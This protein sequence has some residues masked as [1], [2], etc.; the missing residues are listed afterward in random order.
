[1]N[2]FYTNGKEVYD[3][4]IARP[5]DFIHQF[6]K[7]MANNEFLLNHFGITLGELNGLA[8]YDEDTDLITRLSNVHNCHLIDY[9]ISDLFCQVEAPEDEDIEFNFET[10]KYLVEKII[11]HTVSIAMEYDDKVT[12]DRLSRLKE[13]FPKGMWSYETV[14]I[15]ECSCPNDVELNDIRILATLGEVHEIAN[16]A[17][18]FG[19][20]QVLEVTIFEATEII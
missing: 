9:L 8:E 2:F 12:V 10:T 5:N 19:E 15:E 13:I 16:D 3:R 17:T 7:K 1:M 6:I 11:D 18:Y 4:I 20:M 14:N